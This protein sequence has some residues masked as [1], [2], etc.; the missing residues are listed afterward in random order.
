MKIVIY[1]ADKP[2][3]HMLAKAWQLG[4]ESCGHDFELRRIGEYGENAE[5]NDLAYP[6][7]TPDTDV[8]IVFGVKGK[9]RQV[10]DDHQEMGRQ[11]IL[12]DKGYSRAKGE[13]GHT[14]YSRV[15][16]NDLD[17]SSYMMNESRGDDRFR[18]LGIRLER[19][20]KTKG[21]HILFCGST[22]KYHDFH[23]LG[24][25]TE[26]AERVFSKLRKVTDKHFIYR[27]KPSA[28]GMR[29]VAGTS[30]SS[31]RMIMAEA[32]RGCHAVVTHGS[33]AAMDAIIAGVP[34]LVLGKSIAS[35]VSDSELT[36]IE[37]IYYPEND[38]RQQWA[39]NMAYCQWTNEEMRSG[40]AWQYCLS[41][42]ERRS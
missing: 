31:G 25:S 4:I 9:S 27:P 36:N 11:T 10:I 21:G 33:S 35:P 15:I 13:G 2:R 12:L 22:Q 37:S 17:P 6:G 18:R 16:I 1:A 14:E 23:K 7:P 28:R 38:L 41:L 30:Y 3:E 19:H 32:L 29:P 26:Y 39:N 42:L 8:A 5:G 40:E 34:A 20:R 24:D